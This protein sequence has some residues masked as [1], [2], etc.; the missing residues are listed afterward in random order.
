MIKAGIYG[1]RGYVARELARLL[2]AHPEAE[3]AWWYSREAGAVEEAHRNLVGSGMEFTSDEKLS[4][5]DVVFFATPVGVAQEKAAEWLARG[6]KVIAMAA[7]FRLDNRN[8]FERIYGKH[9]CWELAKEAV[10]GI[11]EVYRDKIAKARIVATPGCF[12]TAVILA[13]APLVTDGR[14]DVRR[15]V[16]DGVTGTSGAGAALDR[17]VHHPE[18]CQ[19]MIPYNVVDHRH[20]YEMEA[21]LSKAAGRDVT[22]H[23]TTTMGPF[24]RGILATCHLFCEKTPEREEVLDMLEEYYSDETFV[25]VNRIAKDQKARWDYI[26]YPSVADVAGS[27]Y[28]QLGAAVD[29]KRGRVVVFAALDN[30]GKGA[31]GAA[32]QNMNVMFGIDEATGISQRGLAV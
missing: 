12:A 28:C 7:D 8:D 6:T 5:A 26:A 2:L 30:M 29:E 4:D 25:T 32:V 15:I 17:S 9:K 22:V 21:E 27:N 16:V 14:F 10:Y 19:T 20:T 13:L 1:G 31:C 23:F 24:S 11:P 18:M 3:V